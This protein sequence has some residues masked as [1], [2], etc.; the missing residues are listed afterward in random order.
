MAP[1]ACCL[2]RRQ[3]VLTA[4]LLR[5]ALLLLAAA[6]VAF[7]DGKQH[8]VVCN[9]FPDARPALVEEKERTPT[10][11][12][13]GGGGP[14]VHGGFRRPPLQRILTPDRL[15]FSDFAGV[16]WTRHLAYGACEEYFVDLSTRTLAFLPASKNTSCELL[17]EDAM[18]KAAMHRDDGYASLAVVLTQPLPP[19]P[20]CLVH[21]AALPA[22]SGRASSGSNT[23]EGNKGPL[24]AEL[25]TFD[26]FAQATSGPAA[27]R[28]GLPVLRLEDRIDDEAI[29]VE[30]VGSRMLSFGHA[31]PVEPRAFHMVLEDVRGI[32]EQDRRE[33]SFE[34]GRT[35]VGMRLGRAGDRA[36]PPKLF[37]YPC[38]PPSGSGAGM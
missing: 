15:P 38:N 25:W 2:R 17:A 34:S 9:G 20:R 4:P 5:R 19:S 32:D 12:G 35:Y 11:G 16:V 37:I 24:P 22:P 1:R 28:G 27:L 7:G 6:E 18:K 29:A 3:T 36:F 21:A 13:H 10:G 8:L 30:V 23:G 31:Y 14:R 33:V 26:A